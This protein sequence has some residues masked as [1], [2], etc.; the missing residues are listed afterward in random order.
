MPALPGG[1]QAAGE[2][3]AFLPHG[4][5]FSKPVTVR[6]SFDAALAARANGKPL[7]LFTAAPGG[8]W[9]AVAGARVG[10][11]SVEA[12]VMH[13]SFFVVGF[14]APSQAF[15]A[16][17]INKLDMLFMVDNSFSMQ[18]LQQ[19]LL[20]SFPTLIQTLK[21][22][23]G[24]LPDL[25]IGVVSSSLGAGAY[26]SDQIPNCLHGG[27]Q[28]LLQAMP[29]GACVGPTGAFISTGAGESAKN[30]PGTIEEAFTCIAALGD[31]GCGFEHSLASMARALNADGL[32]LPPENAGF[33]RPEAAL[34]LVMI[35]NEDDCS[36][37]IDSTDIFSP[38]SRL[39]SDP[40]GP[41]A[42]YRCNEFGH[43]CGGQKPPRT[44]AAA[45]TLEDCHSAEDG[46]LIRVAD[47]ARQFKSLKADPSQVFLSVI[48]G[49]VTPYVVKLAPPTLAEDPAMWPSIAHSCMSANG[50]FADPPVRLAELVTAF[51]ANGSLSSICGDFA[52]ALTGLGAALGGALGPRCLQADVVEKGAT[53]KLAAGCS[54]L[55]SVAATGGTRTETPLPVCGTGT[56][57][58]WTVKANT[59]CAAS[60]AELAITRTDAAPAGAVLVVRCAP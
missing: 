43:R 3:F 21:T 44:P 53:P 49:P 31:T 35:T 23:P 8:T 15:P 2:S 32:G 50:E 30:Y 11:S 38:A 13:F 9:A 48:A 19:K 40:M 6:V 55:E 51:G 24:G 46:V 59:A 5:T 56:G 22:L 45:T 34:A 52:P 14:E 47:F 29:R 57:A 10:A 60:G 20:A 26:N 25:H 37:P 18:P 17:P 7:Q 41:L 58:C 42:S 39:V 33:L 28:G 16:T 36:A 12:D 1:V 54:V 27:D 4:T